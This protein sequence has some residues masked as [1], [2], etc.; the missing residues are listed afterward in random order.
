MIII[1]KITKKISIIRLTSIFER[2]LNFF[3]FIKF[4]KFE[5]CINFNKNLIVTYNMS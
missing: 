1:H 2:A 3:D 5:L 4:I